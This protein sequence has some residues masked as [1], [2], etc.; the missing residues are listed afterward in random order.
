MSQK[1]HLFSSVHNIESLSAT[2]PMPPVPFGPGWY[3]RPIWENQALINRAVHLAYMKKSGPAHIAH[4]AHLWPNVSLPVLGTIVTKWGWNRTASFSPAWLCRRCQ[5][6]PWQKFF[7]SN[8]LYWWQQYLME[9]VGFGSCGTQLVGRHI[10]QNFSPFHKGTGIWQRI[11]MTLNNGHIKI[12][13]WIL[14]I[15]QWCWTSASWKS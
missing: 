15:G 8:T 2:R 9:L 10:G 14:G 3:T 6:S 7:V 11:W 1:I 5:E 13:T 4:C 12:H